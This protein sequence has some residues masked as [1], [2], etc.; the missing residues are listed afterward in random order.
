[1]TS[2]VG[3]DRIGYGGIVE[4]YSM[5]DGLRCSEESWKRWGCEAA[6]PFC[7]CGKNVGLEGEMGVDR[8]LESDN[9]GGVSIREV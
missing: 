9:K 7:S 2:I 1:M 8:Y 4:E 6:A 3:L 5:G